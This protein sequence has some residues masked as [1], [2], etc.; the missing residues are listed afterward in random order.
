M[1][2]LQQPAVFREPLA[3]GAY[4]NELIE[5]RAPVPLGSSF[6]DLGLELVQLLQNDG[7][8]LVK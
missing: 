4:L 6:P 2:L 5:Q 3:H 7:I 8:A 1:S